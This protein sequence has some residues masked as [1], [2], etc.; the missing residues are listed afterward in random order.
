VRGE[1]VAA[2]CLNRIVEC[3]CRHE[4]KPRQAPP[5]WVWNGKQ[6]EKTNNCPTKGQGA[7][8]VDR[9]IDVLDKAIEDYAAA[10]KIQPDD[11]DILESLCEAYF[12]RGNEHYN[13]KDYD[14]AI[15]DYTTA[16]ETGRTYYQ[17]PDYVSKRGDAYYIMGDYDKAIADYTAAI[18]I[19]IE[20]SWDKSEYLN[21]RGKAYFG[22][23]YYGKAIAD[24]TAAIEIQPDNPVYLNNRGK[25][26]YNKK[27]YDKSIADYTA[28]IEIQPNNPVFLNNRGK[29]ITAK[30]TAQFH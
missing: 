29:A 16:I 2:K 27:D 14:K 26:Y 21:K 17:Y 12:S 3:I 11:S 8:M 15:E 6:T 4:N 9:E 25:A 19:A 7:K 24:Y 1:Q 30:K 5:P 28:A 10:I 20:I 23:G 22:D 13:K 18:N